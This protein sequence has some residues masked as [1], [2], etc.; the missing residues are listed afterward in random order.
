MEK[1]FFFF[2]LILENI[3]EGEKEGSRVGCFHG[4]RSESTLYV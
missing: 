2:N 4:A 1:G 3:A